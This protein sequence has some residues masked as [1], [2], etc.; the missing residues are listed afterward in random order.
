MRTVVDEARVLRDDNYE[1]DF[2]SVACTGLAILDG[3]CGVDTRR[4][5]VATERRGSGSSWCREG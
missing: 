3:M 4:L 5:M 2:I 1:T